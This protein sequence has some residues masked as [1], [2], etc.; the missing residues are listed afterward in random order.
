MLI[1]NE[2]AGG[3]RSGNQLILGNAQQHSDIKFHNILRLGLG[4]A[5]SFPAF[6][7]DVFYDVPPTNE[8]QFRS[9]HSG[10]SSFSQIICE[11]NIAFFELCW[12]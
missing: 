7:G 5:D 3:L 11:F 9:L 8:D 6:G 12:V 2:R 1:C 10:Y 4:R